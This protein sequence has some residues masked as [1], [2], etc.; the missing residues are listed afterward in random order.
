MGVAWE[1]PLRQ[2]PSGNCSFLSAFCAGGLLFLRLKGLQRGGGPQGED[3]GL[4][5]VEEAA[6]VGTRLRKGRGG[7]TDAS[8]HDV[9]VELKLDVFELSLV[10]AAPA[11]LGRRAQGKST[12][13]GEDVW[14]RGGVRSQ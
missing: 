2:H 5:V 10:A 4:G 8:R 1:S 3:L 7:G 13:Q 12:A 6:L 9:K 11:D 14:Q